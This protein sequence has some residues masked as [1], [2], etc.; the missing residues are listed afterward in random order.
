MASE[1]FFHDVKAMFTIAQM[2]SSST[3]D[4]PM[5]IAAHLSG[6][7]SLVSMGWLRDCLLILSVGE[8]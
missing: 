4:V 8:L 3:L 5:T 1:N 2:Q 6:G 7:L